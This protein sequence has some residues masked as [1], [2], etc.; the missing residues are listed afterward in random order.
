[1]FSVNSSSIAHQTPISS[2][3]APTLR[4]TLVLVLLCVVVL[5]LGGNLLV[6]VA[7]IK[8]KGKSHFKLAILLGI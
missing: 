5:G 3:I 2:I 8:Y 6:L 1:M 7:S 4:L